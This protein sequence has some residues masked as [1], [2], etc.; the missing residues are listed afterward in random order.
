MSVANPKLPGSGVTARILRDDGKTYAG[1]TLPAEI[2]SPGVMGATIA[3]ATGLSASE[4]NR[5]RN[6]N[7]VMAHQPREPVASGLGWAMYAFPGSMQAFVLRDDGTHLSF[8]ASQTVFTLAMATAAL[9]ATAGLSAAEQ[10][11]IAALAT[12]V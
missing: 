10:A 12:P 7:P 8:G 11:R 2:Y 1:A 5:A 3:A 6:A 4:I 9:L